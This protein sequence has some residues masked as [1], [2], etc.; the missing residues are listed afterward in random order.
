[1]TPV[2][3]MQFDQSDFFAVTDS[4]TDADFDTFDF[5]VIG[6]DAEGMVRRYNKLES[7][8]SGLSPAR[9]LGAPL[10]TSVAPC[11]N[12]FMVAQR[13]EDAVANETSLDAI[14][15]Y[16]LT[17]QMRPT[18]VLLRLL[19]QRQTALRYVLIQRRL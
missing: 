19:A 2:P 13:F 11:M 18:K 8:M 4:Y 6:F 16:V 1:M 10:F 12:N 15:D 3:A 14:I 7:Q 9:V 5:G 17:L